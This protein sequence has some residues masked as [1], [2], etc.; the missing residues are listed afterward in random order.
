MDTPDEMKYERFSM[1]QV[2]LNQL[3]N[4]FRNYLLPA[5]FL[6]W[7]ATRSGSPLIHETL[8]RPGGWPS[9]RIIHENAQ[10]VDVLDK[11]A[12]RAS[13][14]SMATRNRRKLVVQMLSEIMCGLQ[15]R[16]NVQLVGVGAGPG[17]HLQEAIQLAGREP[18]TCAIYLI[19]LDPAAA[20]AAREEAASRGTLKSLNAITGDA[21]HIA[22]LL[23]GIQPDLVKLVGLIEYLND[24]EVRSLFDAFYAVMPA[25]AHLLTHGLVDRYGQARF[26]ARTFG[27]RHHARSGAQVQALLQASGFE[28]AEIRVT[29]MRIYPVCHAVR[30][31]R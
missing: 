5:G 23:P 15:N 16:E 26:L 14:I 25:G 7:I 17:W 31:R 30:K 3:L 19:D 6:R 24:Q 22:R 8:R 1:A 13:P 4:P 11:L 12:L 20:E 21:R 29:P 10:P 2:V 27:L 9:M 18:A 28:V